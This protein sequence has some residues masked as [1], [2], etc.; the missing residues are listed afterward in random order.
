MT[1]Y[2]TKA[3]LAEIHGEMDNE[4]GTAL[5]NCFFSAQDFF[6]HFIKTLEMEECRILCAGSS[7]LQGAAAADRSLRKIVRDHG[8]NNT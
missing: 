5:M 4:T 6:E 8:R 1:M 3:E 2:K 7:Y